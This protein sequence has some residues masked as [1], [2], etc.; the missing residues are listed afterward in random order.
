MKKSG[1]R[2][3]LHIYL[4]FFI[5]LLSV[6]IFSAIFLF[7]VVSV[8]TPDGTVVRSNYP[9]EFTENFYEQIIFV[10][11]K[12][13]IKQFGLEL[14]QT[15]NAGIQILDYNGLEITS[16]KKPENAKTIY[17]DTDLLQLYQTGHIN[18]SQST[19]FIGNLTYD[20]NNYTY[21]IHFPMNISKITMY[22]NGD[23]FITGK[24][25]ILLFLGVVFLII[26][27]VGVIYGFWITKIINRISIS[28]K[29]IEKRSYTSA[30]SKGIFQDVFESLDGLDT[31]IKTSD[32]LKE[33]TEK[34]RKEWI[35]NITHDL[36][37]PLSPIKGYAE[38]L[39]EN[40]P[41]SEEL[42]KKYSKVTLKN[43]SYMESLIDDL[44]LTYQLDNAIVPLQCIEQ[45]F[46]RFLKESIIDVLN[47]PEYEERIIHFDYEKE[48][49][50]FYFDRKLMTRAF[51]NLIINAFAHGNN[52]TEISIRVTIFNNTLQIIISDNGNG[53]NTYEVNN[54]FQ[55][56]Y[57]GTNTEKK[58]AGTGLGLAITKSIT[59]AH[60][61]NISVESEVGIGTNFK[62][63][64]PL[65]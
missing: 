48:N 59:E 18:D 5:A 61:G 13:Q 10:D 14:L 51:Q 21:I 28:I 1:Y 27:L 19:S 24:T 52:D 17:S 32:K 8:N 3:I 54:L 53:M 64:F 44:K 25:I 57:R 34:M 46:I 62:I 65:S 60:G 36:K 9:K 20:K 42:I 4:I 33:N 2:S 12:P 35:A 56:Y 30:M 31:E 63:Y 38:V 39:S 49:I 22:L 23:K 50:V 40:K 47:N 43:V 45:N 26:L 7:S 29:S 58:M 16:C 37:T 41:V 15:N 11:D 55:R 6:I